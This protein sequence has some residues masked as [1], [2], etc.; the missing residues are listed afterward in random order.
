M[1]FSEYSIE[2]RIMSKLFSLIFNNNDNYKNNNFIIGSSIFSQ[3]QI[4]AQFTLSKN[5]S[6][7][8]FKDNI[9]GII[10]NNA[11]IYTEAVDVI[12]DRFYYILSSQIQNF[13]S[14][15]EDMRNSAISS[16][17]SNFY[18]GEKFIKLNDIKQMKYDEFC[19][20]IKEYFKEIKYVNFI[21]KKK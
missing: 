21:N 10:I 8:E 17:D 13:K 5:L 12:G 1:R 19:D 16:L 4:Y 6:K 18:D 2:N 9:K 7:E 11:N 14:R 3:N 20:K 15:R